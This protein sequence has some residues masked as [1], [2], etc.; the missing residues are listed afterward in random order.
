MA[1]VIE[2]PVK[3]RAVKISL[4]SQKK[5]SN[6][7]RPASCAQLLFFTGVRYERR[8]NLPTQRLEPPVGSV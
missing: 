8:H 5:K 1:H 4:I 6:R 3:K 7:K 2:F